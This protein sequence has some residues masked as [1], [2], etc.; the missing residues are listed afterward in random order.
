[1]SSATAILSLPCH[2]QNMP[3]LF[4]GVLAVVFQDLSRQFWA[5]RLLTLMRTTTLFGPPSV[6]NSW[7]LE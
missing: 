3:A 5:L 1:M 4:Y 2:C 7:C 6:F